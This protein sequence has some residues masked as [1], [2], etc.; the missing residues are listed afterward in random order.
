VSTYDEIAAQNRREA[1]L[2]MYAAM[3][4]TPPSEVASPVVKVASPPPKVASL[5]ASLGLKVASQLPP[6]PIV[7]ASREP[8]P[9]T[10]TKQQAWR[11]RNRDAYLAWRRA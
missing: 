2:A 8:V 1:V 11:S 7:V 10:G 5:A 9:A 4:C 6:K 3:G